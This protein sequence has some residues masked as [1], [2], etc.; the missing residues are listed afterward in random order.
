MDSRV[1]VKIKA[2]L[3][4]SFPYTFTVVFPD[5]TT[6]EDSA[7]EYWDIAKILDHVSR[8]LLGG[9][10][11]KGQ[12]EWKFHLA[13]NTFTLDVQDQRRTVNVAK[14]LEGLRVAG[15]TGFGWGGKITIDLDS[16]PPKIIHNGVEQNVN[17]VRE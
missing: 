3:T 4:A 8:N 16:H 13:T 7:D 10:H 6:H 9:R 1:S 15:Y 11:L 2:R 17:L 5:G 12:G 14:I